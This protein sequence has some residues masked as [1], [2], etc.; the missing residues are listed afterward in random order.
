MAQNEAIKGEQLQNF[1]FLD[2]PT[3]KEIA[4][5]RNRL[6]TTVQ[7][8]KIMYSTCTFVQSI[9][10]TINTAFASQYFHAFRKFSEKYAAT[11]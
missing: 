1:G 10:C 9:S 8:N 6:D 2:H 4:R 5:G 11:F 3:V 7:S